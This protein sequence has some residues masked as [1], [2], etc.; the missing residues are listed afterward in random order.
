[1][2]TTSRTSSS[3][4]PHIA[5]ARS[6]CASEPGWCMP[7]SNSTTRRR[8]RPPRRCSAARP[9][10]AAAGAGD[11][12]RAARARRGRARAC[13]SPR[14]TGPETT[15]YSLAQQHGERRIGDGRRGRARARRPRRCRRSAANIQQAARAGNASPARRPR[16]SRG[17]TSR[18]SPRATS[19]RAVAMWAEG[20][21]ENVR[22]QVDVHRARGRARVH[23][24]AARRD[25]RPEHGGRHDDHRGRALRGALAPARH[26][27]RARE[28]QRRRAH[29]RPA[30][31]SR[32]S[33]C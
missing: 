30:S 18:R 11:R 19:T 13:G 17:A 16:R 7:V 26:L 33:T 25:A 32:A 24:R 23:R 2:Q 27:R 15:S 14:A 12:R 1:M 10:R 3:A 9:A 5:S 29:R 28:L 20:G 8:P 21:R 31:S 4:R 22:G 6:R